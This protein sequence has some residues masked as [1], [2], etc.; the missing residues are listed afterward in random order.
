MLNAHIVSR[1]WDGGSGVAFGRQNLGMLTA[2]LLLASLQLQ[3]P[4]VVHK[5]SGAMPTGVAVSHRGRI[6]V[7]YPRWGDPVKATVAEIVHEH[8]VP[9]PSAT[10]NMNGKEDPGNKLVSVQSVY[11]DPD[12]RLWLVDTGSVKFGPVLPG[13]AKLV[14]M[15]LNNNE[16]LRTIPIKSPAI[17][18][19][20]YLNDI[21]FDLRKGKRGYAFLTD[22]T[23]K[24]PNGIVVV[25][26]DTGESWRRLNNH[27]STKADP[28][29]IPVVEGE[30]LMQRPKSKPP[31]KLKMGADGIAI[32]PDGVSLYYCPLISTHLYSVSVDALVDRSLTDEQVAAT[33]KDLGEK[34]ASDGLETDS[35][36]NLYFTDYQNNLIK[37]GPPSTNYDTIVKLDKQWW[38]DTLFVATDGFVYF[39]ANQLQ[40][41]PMFHEGKDLRVKPYLLMRVQAAGRPVMTGR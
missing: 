12:D 18:E 22:S 31:Q 14:C 25:D 32:S 6:F 33:V 20:S 4:E 1:F 26:L 37:S 27:P 5:F 8:E 15:N 19:T 16:V 38:P 3:T 41:Q 10:M 13:G 34:G 23:D 2:A 39:T 21:R 28:N 29:F 40:R 24:G 17:H 30:K 7:C 9:Y 36:R 35:E 11:V